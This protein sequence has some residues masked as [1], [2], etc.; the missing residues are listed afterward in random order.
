VRPVEA[1]KRSVELVRGWDLFQRDG[2]LYAASALFAAITGRLSSI[3]AYRQW[4]EVAAVAYVVGAVASGLLHRLT[5]SRVAIVGSGP[6]G[7]TDVPRGT[8]VTTG[9]E[10]LMKS[11]QAQT[12]ARTIVLLFVMVGATLLPLS[13][14]VVWRTQQGGTIHAQPE[15]LVVEHSAASLL[16]GH[17]P[18]TLVNPAHP[19]K[20]G[21]GE[22]SSDAFDPYLPL[23][24]AL[25]L[26]RSTDASPRLTDARIVF[27]VVTILIVMAALCL[28]RGPASEG[29]LTVQAMTTLPMAALPLATGGDDLP[30]AAFMLLAVVLLQRRR[31]LAGGVAMGVAASMKI[32]AWPLALL[33][34]MVVT[35]KNGK[36]DNKARSFYLLGLLGIFL[37]VVIPAVFDNVGA[38]V[39]DVVKFPLGLAGISSPADSP[40]LGH[41]VIVLFPK[42]HRVFTVVVGSASVVLGGIA[43]FKWRPRNVQ[44]LCLFTGLLSGFVILLAPSSR[45]GYLLYPVNLLAWSGMMRADDAASGR[46][47]DSLSGMDELVGFDDSSD[48]GEG[49]RTWVPAL[50]GDGQDDRNHETDGVGPVQVEVSAGLPLASDVDRAPT[51]R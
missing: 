35:D 47:S 3:L 51:N 17:D 41:V 15:V 25:G 44:Q 8:L 40:F 9:R 31:P 29:L 49:D 21:Y 20:V 1:A 10:P 13:L 22:P 5:A 45:I 6:D 32:T 28:C 48:M 43:L 37:P 33:A 27:S 26:A 50:V 2:V 36:H 30:V 19:P 46:V 7:Q 24:S 4:G 16:H 23:M 14:Q 12:R 42:L 34:L 11:A 18:Y 38:F 39:D